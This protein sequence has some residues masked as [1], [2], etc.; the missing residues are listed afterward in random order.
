MRKP[1]VLFIFADQMRADAMGCAGHPMIKTP[2]LDSIAENGILFSNAYTPCPICVPARA[3]VTTGNYPHKCT[4]YKSNSGRIKDGEIKMASHFSENGYVSYA[5]GKLHYCPYSKPGEARLVHGFDHVSLAESGRILAHYDSE[6]KMRGLEDYHDY[7][8]DAGWSGFDRAHGIGNNDIHPG[9][10]PLPEEHFVDSWVCSQAINYLEQ[11]KREH[12]EKPFFMFMS[13]PKPHAP[14]DPPA[15]YNSMYDSR[16]VPGPLTQIDSLT[17]A[18]EKHREKISHGW[19]L[20]SPE[21][22]RAARACYY[23]LISFQ[24]KQIGRMLDYLKQNNLDE[25]TIIIYSADHGDMIGDFGF[26][27]KTCFYKG[28]VNVP[29]LIS[30]PKSLPRGIKSDELVGLQDILPTISNLAGIPINKEVDGVDILSPAGRKKERDYYIS[31]CDSPTQAYM[32]ADK[33]YKYIYSELNGTEE[34]YDLKLDPDELENKINI[35]QY[36]ARITEMKQKMIKWAVDNNEEKILDEN[37]RL[38]V[39]HDDSQG[40]F[41]FKS[42]GWRWY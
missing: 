24:D 7:L 17:R 3:A 39:T 11:H 2:N 40:S 20:F 38:K 23:G 27:A 25:N 34:F 10:S 8:K 33:N 28:S 21:T 22:H 5:S 31:Y 30:Y 32:I 12:V 36:A 15:P 26:F 6:G 9:V 19:N 37:Q 42:M 29:M 16:E 35:P 4:G 1:N 14:Y 41:N 18:P 13:F